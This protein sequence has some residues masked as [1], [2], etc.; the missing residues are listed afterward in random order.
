MEDGWKL[1][2]AVGFIF[3]IGRQPFLFPR[4]FTCP[5]PLIYAKPTRKS[6]PMSIPVSSEKL[7][8]TK[9]LRHKEF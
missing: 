6:S 7:F 5:I 3:A 4:K 2:L 1:V 8:T 9:T